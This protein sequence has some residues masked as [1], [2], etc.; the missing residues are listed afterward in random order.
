MDRE[1]LH[2][3]AN[4]G[5]YMTGKHIKNALVPTRCPSSY[6]RAVLIT[7]KAQIHRWSSTF[8]LLASKY[9]YIKTSTA[10]THHFYTSAIVKIWF[11]LTKHDVNIHTLI[12]IIPS[13]FRQGFPIFFYLHRPGA[14]LCCSLHQTWCLGFIAEVWLQTI[15]ESGYSTTAILFCTYI[16][17]GAQ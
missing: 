10:Q 5:E 8:V 13:S 7:A 6:I 12:N 16:A 2:S 4:R 14:G 17:I 3:I 9:T 15:N 11:L 1:N